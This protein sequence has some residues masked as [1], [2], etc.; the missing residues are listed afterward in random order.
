VTSAIFIIFSYIFTAVASGGTVRVKDTAKCAEM[1]LSGT[2][3][4]N[5]DG[6][7]FIS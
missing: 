1:L 5:V 2:Q 7:K 3:R 4:E 6:T